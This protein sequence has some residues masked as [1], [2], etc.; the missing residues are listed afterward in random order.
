MTAKWPFNEESFPL[1]DPLDV[2]GNS[3]SLSLLLQWCQVIGAMVGLNVSVSKYIL[4]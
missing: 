4:Y 2:Y 3:Q 1:K